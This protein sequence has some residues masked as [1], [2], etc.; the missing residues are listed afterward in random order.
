MIIDI[1][2]F[3]SGFLTPK[4]PFSADVQSQ[5]VWSI[6]V[7]LKV[8]SPDPEHQHNLELLKMQVIRPHPRPTESEILPFNKSSRIQVIL[9]RT[10][11]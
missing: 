9:L 8:W 3:I 4:I 10:K 7:V 1:C 5:L 2:F 6:A 11:V